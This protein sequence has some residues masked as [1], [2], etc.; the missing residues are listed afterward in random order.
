LG[1]E[2]G[3]TSKEKLKTHLLAAMRSGQGGHW[4]N[5]T[6][7][8]MLRCFGRVGVGD[9]LEQ[10]SAVVAP[11]RPNKAKYKKMENGVWKAC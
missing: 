8:N 9:H 4:P 5:V 7:P 3:T 1:I 6:H 11:R 2:G 10:R